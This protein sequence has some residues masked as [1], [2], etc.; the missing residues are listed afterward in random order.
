MEGSETSGVG[1]LEFSSIA[2]AKINAYVCSTETSGTISKAK[3]N[4]FL[5]Q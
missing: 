2:P 1:K 3:T 4:L 5:T